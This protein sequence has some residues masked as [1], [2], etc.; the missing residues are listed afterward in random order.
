MQA[1]H[2]DGWT[3]MGGGIEYGIET[4]TTLPAR[5]TARKIMILLTD[6]NAKVTRSGEVPHGNWETQQRIYAEARQ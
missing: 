4:L 6:G 1:G 2:F 3:N 5:D